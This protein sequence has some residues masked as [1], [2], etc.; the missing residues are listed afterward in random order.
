MSIKNFFLFFVSKA[1]LLNLVVIIMASV[2]LIFGVLHWLDLYTQHGKV[3]IVPDLNGL[4][5][6]E[7][8]HKLKQNGLRYEVV[9]SVFHLQSKPGVVM[10]QHP[11]ANARVKNNRIIFLTVNAYSP[12]TISVPDVK[13]M[14]QRQASAILV[15]SGFALG[16]IQYVPSEYRDLVIDM[17]YNGR[18]IT[19]GEKLPINTSIDLIVGKGHS[20]EM[21]PMP[22]FHGLTLEEATHKASI[23]SLVIGGVFYDVTPQDEADKA[24]YVVY[25]QSPEY[26]TMTP[27]G[28][29]IDLYL[30]KDKDQVTKPQEETEATN[31]QPVKIDNTEESWF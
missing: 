20:N 25:Q 12:L 13:D 5:I 7:S 18:P 6:E 17:Q 10:D 31:K 19:T 4:S 23:E 22:S 11:K 27:K 21:I 14:S 9:D 26:G 2:G 16:E 15:G 8:I 3:E 29:A 24:L 1:F 30:T 28:K